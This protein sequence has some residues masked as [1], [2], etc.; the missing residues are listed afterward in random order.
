[1]TTET[2]AD[3]LL[4]ILFKMIVCCFGASAG[5][6]TTLYMTGYDREKFISI[7]RAIE[8][9]APYYWFLFLL[10]LIVIFSQ[11]IELL[12]RWGLAEIHELLFGEK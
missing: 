3:M 7:L 10:I 12:V 5:A 9:T 6:V 1:M 2:Y 4:S 11:L 8:G